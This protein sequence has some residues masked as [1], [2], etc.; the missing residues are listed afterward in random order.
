MHF[1]AFTLICNTHYP[2]FLSLLIILHTC[3]AYCFSFS[4]LFALHSV[5]MSFR[6]TSFRYLVLLF[7]FSTLIHFRSFSFHFHFHFHFPFIFISLLFSFSFYFKF[8]QLS[9]FFQTKF[10]FKCSIN[11][12][13]CIK[14]KMLSSGISITFIYIKFKL[15]EAIS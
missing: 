1:H 5:F 4:F 6:K 13:D 7:F 15:Y 14:Y 11:S 10:E 9:T 8:F 2:F 12:H 3:Q